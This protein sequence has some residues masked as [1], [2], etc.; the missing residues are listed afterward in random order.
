MIYDFAR[1]SGWHIKLYSEAGHGMSIGLYLPALSNGPDLDHLPPTARNRTTLEMGK[2][3]HILVVEDKPNVRQI[4]VERL[5][6][7]NYRVSVAEDGDTDYH[8]PKRNSAYDVVLSDI[9]MLG[10]M[11]GFELATRIRSKFPKVK[12]MLTSDYASD[13]II[14]K[15]HMSEQF[16]V[17]HKPYHQRELARRLSALLAR[18]PG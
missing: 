10:T 3:E 8:I 4:S 5:L 11:N 16:E 6:A 15:M 2:G 18:S 14:E 12:A 9:V 1:Q 17:L 13:V 7:L